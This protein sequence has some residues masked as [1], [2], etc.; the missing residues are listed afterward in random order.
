MSPPAPETVLL[1]GATGFVGRRLSERLAR[2]GHEVTV[3]VREASLKGFE[4]WLSGVRR[5]NED[6]WKRILVATGDIRRPGLFDQQKLRTRNAAE[7]RRIFHC[8]AATHLAVDPGS[9]EAVNVEGTANVL[10]FAREAKQLE[11]LVY[12]SAAAVAG[13]HEGRFDEDMLGEGQG[14]YNHYASSKLRAEERVR[15]TMGELPLTVLRPSHIVGDS[16][17][18]SVEKVDGVY[19][20]FLLLIRLAKLPRPLRVLPVAPG[21]AVARIDMVPIDF[22]IDAAVASAA[23]ESAL[24]KTLQLADPETMTVG[25]LA[26]DL[27]RRLGIRGPWLNL[28]GRP[29]AM[30]LRERNVSVLRDLVDQVICLPPELAD[31]LAHRASYDTTTADRVLRPLGL[32][33]PPVTEYLDTLLDYTQKRLT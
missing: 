9:A 5:S 22:V 28:R 21:G 6:C 8:A 24:G 27:S 12:F 1:T 19:H 3:L 29:L 23:A 33:P 32:S 20:L 17:D 14:F 4:T 10:D 18:G 11:R 2:D 30:L 31:G 7:A 25:E 16:R 15:E 26:R 13:D